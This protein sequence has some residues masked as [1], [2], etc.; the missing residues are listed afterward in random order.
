M[1]DPAKRIICRICEERRLPLFDGGRACWGCLTKLEATD[2]IY[3]EEVE[4][5]RE[6]IRVADATK[7]FGLDR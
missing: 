4:G 5:Y 6:R 7:Q 1:I 2:P 3:R